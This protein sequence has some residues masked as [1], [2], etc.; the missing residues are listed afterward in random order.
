MTDLERVIQ[1]LEDGWLTA[2]ATQGRPARKR[3]HHPGWNEGF[4]SLMVG[5]PD[6]GQGVVWMANG[7]NGKR[8][9]REVMRGIP[10]AFGWSGY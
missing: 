5:C 4:Y 9:G 10:E 2:T 6:T 3:F 8:L 1:A 7:E